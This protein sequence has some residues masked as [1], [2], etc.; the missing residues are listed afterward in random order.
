V[1][2]VIIFLEE[3]K[4]DSKRKGVMNMNK[5]IN[6]IAVLSILTFSLV[7]ATVYGSESIS[8]GWER[9][10]QV[11]EILGSVVMNHEG[12]YLGRVQD[13]VF[14]PDGHVVFAIVGNWRWNWRII[15]ENS[16][17]VPFSELTYDHNGKH[18]V[19]MVDISWEKFQSA[20]KFR[21]ADLTDRRRAEEVY[22]YFGQ[23]PYWTE[24]GSTGMRSHTMEKSMKGQTVK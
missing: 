3:F 1:V 11:N 6:L 17:A 5:F 7:V 10:Y 19:V 8:K 14:D 21:K 22:K 16:V 20:P 4:T 9:S 13:L 2:S 15:G 18:P 24:G 23:Q 12:K